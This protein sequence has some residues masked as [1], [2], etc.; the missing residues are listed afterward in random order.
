MSQWRIVRNAPAIHMRALQ[1]ALSRLA[2]MLLRLALG[3]ECISSPKDHAC[4]GEACGQR[5]AYFGRLRLHS[6]PALVRLTPHVLRSIE[7]KLGDQG[8]RAEACDSLRAC[9]SAQYPARH[10]MASPTSTLVH[11]EK[12]ERHESSKDEYL[13]DDGCRCTP[14]DGRW[15]VPSQPN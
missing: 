15:N 9:Q 11:N 3:R 14:V 4:A 7:A 12:V 5:A 8:E 13:K 6:R 1:H 2:V 10:E